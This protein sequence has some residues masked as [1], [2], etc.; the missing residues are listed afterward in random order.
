MFSDLIQLVDAVQKYAP[1][2]TLTSKVAR[3]GGDEIFGFCKQKS[4]LFHRLKWDSHWH[5]HVN[6]SQALPGKS[7]VQAEGVRFNFG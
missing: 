2:T 4:N 6:F 1:D 7:H 3:F 5:D